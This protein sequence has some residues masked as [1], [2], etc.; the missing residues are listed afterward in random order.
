MMHLAPSGEVYEAGTFS[1]NPITA[2]A[3]LATLD[4]MLP[5]RYKK[6]AKRSKKIQKA[7]KDSLDDR[8]V[9]GCVNQVPSMF[10]VFFGRRFVSDAMDARGA[11]GKRYDDMFRFMLK[12]GFYLPPSKME[13]NFL[14]VA[15]NNEV[16]DRF[17]ET[18][19]RFLG[20]IQ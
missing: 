17:C 5:C 11:D 10:Q 15:H 19:D 12:E 6:L 14:S 13:V 4:E 16:V 9:Q 1:G 8:N 18:F 2:V 7:M 20:E 3:G